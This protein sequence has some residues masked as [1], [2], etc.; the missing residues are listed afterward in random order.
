[1]CKAIYNNN[2]NN[3]DT[4]DVKPRYSWEIQNMQ[5]QTN[6]THDRWLNVSY[7]SSGKYT[8]NESY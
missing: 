4:N 2:N 7:F 1:M 6:K 8:K 3:I 5:T